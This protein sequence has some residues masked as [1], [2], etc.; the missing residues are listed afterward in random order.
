MEHFSVSNMYV[1]YKIFVYIF[2]PLKVFGGSIALSHRI[3]FI[4]YSL[5]KWKSRNGGSQNRH[6]RCWRDVILSIS[7][8][9]CWRLVVW[10]D[11]AKFR[12]FVTILKVLGK[13]LR[14]YLVFGN[15]FDPTVA[16][17]LRYRASFIVVNNLAIWSRW[18][19]VFRFPH[20]TSIR[21][22][23]PIIPY[24]FHG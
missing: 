12:R 2:L 5:N 20:L 19:L 17:M 16:K 4:M 11:L 3:S 24:D 8:D 10:P 6:S 14:V 18:W 9:T 23:T 13:F 1:F 22:V 15:K 21:S 7:I